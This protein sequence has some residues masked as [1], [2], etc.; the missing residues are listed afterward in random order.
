M[1]ARRLIDELSS[2]ALKLGLEVRVEPFATPGRSAGGLCRIRGR[3]V[4]LIDASAGLLEQAAS[5][6]EALGTFELEG[7]YMAPEA[8]R[9]IE[10]RR[11]HDE[12]HRE[13]AAPGRAEDNIEP[14]P[15]PKPGL[16]ST[17]PD[18]ER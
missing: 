14:L 16:R 10:Q 6:A 3:L 9:F 1:D 18:R 17:K 7:V 4:V 13:P 15:L 8:R 12:W 2:V 11:E 5:L